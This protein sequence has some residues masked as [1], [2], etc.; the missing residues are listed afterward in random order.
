MTLQGALEHLQQRSGLQEIG[1]RWEGNERQQGT[2]APSTEGT[3]SF[4]SI[5]STRPAL[6]RPCSR[7]KASLILRPGKPQGICLPLFPASLSRLRPELVPKAPASPSIRSLGAAH[8]LNIPVA[9]E[10][11]C[12]SCLHL[13]DTV[14]LPFYLLRSAQSQLPPESPP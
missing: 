14:L 2:Q 4:P 11:P 10:H 3:S 7:I 1:T 6:Y 13:S 12:C 5:P 8:Y 9:P